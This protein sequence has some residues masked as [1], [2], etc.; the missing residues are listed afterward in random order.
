LGTF[1]V[2]SQKKNLLK[3]LKENISLGFLVIKKHVLKITPPLFF[4]KF[5]GRGGGLSVVI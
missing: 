4:A 5:C 2:K 3:K 1:S